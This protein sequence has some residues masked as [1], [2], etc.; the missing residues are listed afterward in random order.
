MERF[1]KNFGR[2][3]VTLPTDNRVWFVN[4][5]CL[6]RVGINNPP[7]NKCCWFGDYR[8]IAFDYRVIIDFVWLY[9]NLN[10]GYHRPC[11]LQLFSEISYFNYSYFSSILSLVGCV[12]KHAHYRPLWLNRLVI[13][14]WLFTLENLSGK[15][16]VLSK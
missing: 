2:Q 15:N 10:A 11:V 1:Q 9:I 6:F 12:Q 16:P 7:D 3:N 8:I 13:G 5:M 4:L 14:C